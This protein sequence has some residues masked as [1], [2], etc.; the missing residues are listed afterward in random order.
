[1]LAFETWN[2]AGRRKIME[3]FQPKV[4]GRIPDESS[5][6]AS[7]HLETNGVV[8]LIFFTAQTLTGL[9][10]IDAKVPLVGPAE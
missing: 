6:S 7:F 1:V 4:D 5:S 9:G 2:E 8:E 10:R 3:L